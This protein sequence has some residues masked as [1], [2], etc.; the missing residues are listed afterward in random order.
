MKKHKSCNPFKLWG[1]YIG[2]LLGGLVF[3]FLTQTGYEFFFNKLDIF[4]S[5][6]T[7]ISDYRVLIFFVFTGSLLG[8]F[9]HCL[10]K[11]CNKTK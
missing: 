2:G 11:L 6:P 3:Y 5:L 9:F 7:L 10:F 4:N 1:L 8:L